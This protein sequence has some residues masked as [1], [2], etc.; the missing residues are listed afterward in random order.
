M[1]RHPIK[2]RP[3]AAANAGMNTDKK[4]SSKNLPR[5]LKPIINIFTREETDTS[6]MWMK[7][8]LLS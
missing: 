5:S 7:S 4:N 8:A 2:K 3:R 1:F 6:L